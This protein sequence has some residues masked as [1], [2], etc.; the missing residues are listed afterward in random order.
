[1]RTRIKSASVTTRLASCNACCPNAAGVDGN[2][3]ERITQE[4][5]EAAIAQLQGNNQAAE[6]VS[7]I[8]AFDVPK[9]S[10]DPVGRKLYADHQP[11][12]VLAG[13]QV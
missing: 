10:Y 3:A 4:S 9:I 2:H 6:L 13:S 8:N 1:M 11:R 5:I 12:T 7:V